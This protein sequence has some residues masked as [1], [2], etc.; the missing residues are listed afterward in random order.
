MAQSELGKAG[1]PPPSKAKAQNS[2]AGVAATPGGQKE[3]V[4]LRPT[5]QHNSS[6][7]SLLD[8]VD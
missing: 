5:Q 1:W 4:P 8:L 7:L 6:L 3:A 2:P